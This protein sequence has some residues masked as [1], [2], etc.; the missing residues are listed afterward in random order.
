[1]STMRS[2]EPLTGIDAVLA[3]IFPF[4][5]ETEPEVGE[6]GVDRRGNLY[7]RTEAGTWSLVRRE[8]EREAQAG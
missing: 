3:R 1:M 4:L 5:N 6:H 7:V 2:V 8:P